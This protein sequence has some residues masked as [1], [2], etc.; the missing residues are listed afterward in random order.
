MRSASSLCVQRV[1]NHASVAVGAG[2]LEV[3]VLTV[4]EETWPSRT[5]GRGG[6]LREEGRRD[7]VNAAAGDD[8][9]A[10]AGDDVNAAAGDA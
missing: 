5:W 8:V 7:D 4:A 9:N 3:R 1:V 6:G 10:A 2:M